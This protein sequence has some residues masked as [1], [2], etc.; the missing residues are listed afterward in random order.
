MTQSLTI[1]KEILADLLMKKEKLDDIE[2]KIATHSADSGK[3]VLFYLDSI[4][5]FYFPASDRFGSFNPWDKKAWKGEEMEGEKAYA[6]TMEKFKNVENVYYLASSAL[7]EFTKGATLLYKTKNRN[8][9]I[10]EEEFYLY[11]LDTAT[12]EK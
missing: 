4:H 1:S 2:N 5:S 6:I 7:P 3:T 9:F 8:E 12:K 10:K 11:K